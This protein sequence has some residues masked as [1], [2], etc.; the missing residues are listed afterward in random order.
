MRVVFRHGA[1]KT[2]HAGSAQNLGDLCGKINILV[3]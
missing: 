2:P 3:W 1:M